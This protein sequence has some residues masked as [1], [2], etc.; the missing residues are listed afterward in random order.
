MRSSR[1][2]M[3]TFRVRNS[4]SPVPSVIAVGVVMHISM[5]PAWM[6]VVFTLAPVVWWVR[7]RLEPV[8]LNIL[9]FKQF[10]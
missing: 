6:F 4:M 2:G 9:T 8:L 5:N 7:W 1:V 3:E 10:K